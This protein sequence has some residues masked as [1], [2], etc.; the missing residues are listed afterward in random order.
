MVSG[1]ENEA[2]SDIVN[3]GSFRVT[4]TVLVATI[5]SLI[6]THNVLPT[7]LLISIKLGR[8]NYNFLSLQVLP[9]LQAFDLESFVTERHICPQKFIEARI[10][11]SGNIT[12]QIN[13]DFLT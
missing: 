2:M 3:G 8:S 5:V 12:K 4:S 11:K 7:L 9:T 10:D 1:N 13:P 6:V